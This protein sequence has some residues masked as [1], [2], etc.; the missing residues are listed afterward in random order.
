MRPKLYRNDSS[1]DFSDVPTQ[2]TRQDRRLMKE[3][4]I[5]IVRN[6]ISEPPAPSMVGTTTRFYQYRTFVSWMDQRRYSSSHHSF[7]GK[8]I[9]TFE[10]KIM[11]YACTTAM[12]NSGFCYFQ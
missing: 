2:V 1:N 11:H 7:F 9:S 8:R 5:W 6:I 12:G 3:L 4:V 10:P